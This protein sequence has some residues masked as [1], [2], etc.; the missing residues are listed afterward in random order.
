[1]SE[2]ADGD[3]SPDAVPIA[4]EVP[5][6]RRHVSG[7]DAGRDAGRDPG[8]DDPL[9]LGAGPMRFPDD[10]SLSRTVRQIDQVLGWIEQ[11]VV[12]ALL[13]LV[14]SVAALAALHDRMA[15]THIGRWWHY[16]VRGGTFATAMFAAVFA[17]QQQRHLAMDLVSRRI[18]PRGR[19]ILGVALKLLTIGVMVLLFQSGL[20]Q[21]A[22]AGGNES[23]DVLGLHVVDADIVSTISIGAAL[24]GLHA[25][26]HLVID[27]DYLIRG[28]LP[29][30]RARSGH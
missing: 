8:H 19:L 11:A 6:T 7:H 24:I 1:V 15:A 29:P 20:H 30:E 25:L 27:I 14:V 10:G 5:P 2:P 22:V 3:G 16:I 9:G 17:T 21:R 26:L 23:L 12:F 28:K 18:S 13:A 4:A